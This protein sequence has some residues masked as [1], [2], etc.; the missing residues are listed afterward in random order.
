MK[1]SERSVYMAQEL[2]GTGR[3]DLVREVET[4]RMKL[5]AALRLAKPSKYAKTPNGLKALESA[6]QAA[7][8]GERAYFVAKLHLV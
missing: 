7:S 6:R 1:V 4:G 8:E 2:C 5:H 3:D